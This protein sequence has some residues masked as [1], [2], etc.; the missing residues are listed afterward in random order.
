MRGQSFNACAPHQ[1]TS[2]VPNCQVNKTYVPQ[3]SIKMPSLSLLP[4]EVFLFP[5][6]QY[7][8]IIWLA[9][10][11]ESLQG[12]K[13][14][15][16]HITHSIHLLHTTPCGQCHCAHFTKGNRTRTHIRGPVFANI[17]P[18]HFLYVRYYY[19]TPLPLPVCPSVLSLQ[20]Q[21]KAISNHI[22]LLKT[23]Q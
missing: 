22:L 4:N 15:A 12:A 6:C 21:Q 1:K 16:K 11:V 23:V 2:M 7:R 13:Q 19:T 5:S 20:M 10:G 18:G 17:F 8:V 9:T 14:P 3:L